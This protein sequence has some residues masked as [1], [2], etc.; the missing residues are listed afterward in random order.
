MKVTG[1]DGEKYTI[2]PKA[3]LSG[4]DLSFAY[5]EG[6]LCTDE[7]FFP[8]GFSPDKAGV[9]WIGPDTNLSHADL[10]GINLSGADLGGLPRTRS[11]PDTSFKPLAR[12]RTVIRNRDFI[13]SVG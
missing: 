11:V 13:S 3:N 12:G 5:L 9:L 6:A 4:L 10:R 8:E 2:E 1:T 7:T